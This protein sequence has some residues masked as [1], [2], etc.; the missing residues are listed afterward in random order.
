M[1]RLTYKPKH[2]W[3]TRCFQEWALD[4]WVK[5]AQEFET[6]W[7]ESPAEPD[8][9]ASA[10]EPLTADGIPRGDSFEP[11]REPPPQRP[12]TENLDYSDQGRNPAQSQETYYNPNNDP[13]RRNRDPRD[14]GSSRP[15]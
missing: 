1:V 11:E 15:Y 9:F 12:R 3:L 6:L 10:T 4:A 8:A 14:Q 5:E 2:V 7:E 13:R